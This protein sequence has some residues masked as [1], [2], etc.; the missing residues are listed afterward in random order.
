LSQDLGKLKATP[1][2]QELRGQGRAW[3]EFVDRAQAAG[4]EERLNPEDRARL[5]RARIE[6]GEIRAD[7]AIA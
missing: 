2:F 1:A 4:T 6:A 5:A 3:Y 7:R